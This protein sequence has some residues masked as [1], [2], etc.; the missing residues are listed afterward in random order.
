[1][2]CHVCPWMCGCTSY[3]SV[4]GVV[5]ISVFGTDASCLVVAG[6]PKGSTDLEICEHALRECG[7]EKGD[8]GKWAVRS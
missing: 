7:F 3:M 1:M 5:G 8:E 4:M 6:A 2:C